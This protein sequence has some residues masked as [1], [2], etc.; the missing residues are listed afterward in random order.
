VAYVPEEDCAVIAG[1]R[2]AAAGHIVLVL[3][4]PPA[5]VIGPAELVDAVASRVVDES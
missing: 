3:R 5:S 4:S 1:D 2:H